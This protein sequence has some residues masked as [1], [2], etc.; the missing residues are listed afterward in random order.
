MEPTIS[1]KLNA[2]QNI[3]RGGDY[4]VILWYDALAW[5]EI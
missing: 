3:L 1:I 5:P 2:Y 4:S